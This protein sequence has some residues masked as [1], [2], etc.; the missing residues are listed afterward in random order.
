MG[1]ADGR[2]SNKEAGRKRIVALG[3]VCSA[4]VRGMGLG[5]GDWG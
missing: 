3:G 2:G 1:A 4:V 5:I